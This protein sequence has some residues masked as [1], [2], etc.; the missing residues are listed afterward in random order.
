MD[1]RMCL[2]S[3]DVWMSGCLCGVSPLLQHLWVEIVRLA[4]QT[5]LCTDLWWQPFPCSLCRKVVELACTC[6]P[7]Q[8]CGCYVA[9]G[10]HFPSHQEDCCGCSSWAAHRVVKSVI[11][12]W[13]IADL[14]VQHSS[15]EL[16]AEFTVC[17]QEA[18]MVQLTL[19]STLCHCRKIEE[20]KLHQGS[21][22]AS[23]FLWLGWD[24]TELGLFVYFEMGSHPLLASQVLEV[25]GTWC[26]AWLIMNVADCRRFLFVCK[27]CASGKNV[28]IWKVDKRVAVCLL[29]F[30]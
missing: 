28:W 26:Q 2:W 15:R 4:W 10:R 16:T 7:S 1:V 21:S 29:N 8:V 13:G 14:I 18:K 11:P 9:L 30:I 25:L 20:V 19:K 3:W 23:G 27:Y 12:V 24:L 17:W 6:S 5:L 22:I